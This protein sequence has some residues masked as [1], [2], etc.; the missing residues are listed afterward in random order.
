MTSVLV[1]TGLL[2][3]LT[4]LLSVLKPPV[5]LR[6]KTRRAGAALLLIGFGLGVLG[7]A[8]PAGLHHSEGRHTRIDDFMPAYHFHEFHSTRIHA[9]PDRIFRAIKAV[10]PR[11]IRTVGAV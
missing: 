5:F 9:S 2:L 1:Y 7:A 8:W 10:T 4:G 11:E 3:T 6:I